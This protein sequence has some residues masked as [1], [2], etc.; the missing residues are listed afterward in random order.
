MNHLTEKEHIMPDLS[1]YNTLRSVL[2]R[3]GFNLKK[4]L[5]QNFLIDPTVC[6]AMA[7]EACADA[8]GII[9][10][11]P[12]AGVLT[13][14]LAKRAKKVVAV[15][16]D[17]KLEPVLKETLEPYGNAEV[18]FGDIMKIDLAALIEEKFKGMDVAVCANLPYYITSPIIMSLLERQKGLKS[19]TVMVQKE[20][21]ERLCAEMGTRECGAVTAAVRYYC[22]PRVLFGVDRTSFM[23]PPKVD[24]AVIKLDITDHPTVDVDRNAFFKVIKAAFSMRR[25]TLANCLSAGLK[26]DKTAVYELL[27][28]CSVNRDARGEQLTMEQFAELAKAIIKE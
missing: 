16:I 26:L 7:D 4:S 21:A 11:G 5:G 1:N 28:S 6:P 23:P 20:A 8:D 15:E 18:V 14:E 27:D 12:G 2:E 22:A 25:K 3:N 9:E 24:S 13:A 19:I 17:K 10:I